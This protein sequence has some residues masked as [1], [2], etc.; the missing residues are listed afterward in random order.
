MFH[1]GRQADLT[2]KARQ[3]APLLYYSSDHLGNLLLAFS[4]L[5]AQEFAPCVNAD[6]ARAARL[7][8]DAFAAAEA[9]MTAK[10]RA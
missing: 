10:A 5:S 8:T 6:Q 3:D 9:P 1:L 4:D 2:T 7:T